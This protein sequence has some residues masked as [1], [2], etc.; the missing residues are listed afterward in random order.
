MEHA[1]GPLE[2]GWS[3]FHPSDLREAL[4][5]LGIEQ[6]RYRTDHYLLSGNTANARSTG[7]THC[8]YGASGVQGVPGARQTGADAG[9]GTV[10]TPRWTRSL[11]SPSSRASRVRGASICIF[12]TQNSKKFT[13]YLEVTLC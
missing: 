9:G 4:E 12:I 2:R 11:C 13:K 3:G 10:R 7:Q 5:T 1:T 8:R 6:Q